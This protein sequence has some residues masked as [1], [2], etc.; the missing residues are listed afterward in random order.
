MRFS[1][2]MLFVVGFSLSCSLTTNAG[3]TAPAIPAKTEIDIRDISL[4]AD[5]VLTGY[6]VNSQGQPVSSAEV[7]VSFGRR[8]I[9]KVKTHPKTGVFS[10]HKL[11]GGVHT[12]VVNGQTTIVRFWPEASAPPS[13]RP[14]LTI[15]TKDKVV[16]AQNVS[17]AL[18]A[19]SYN[20]QSLE[21][22][23]AFDNGMD[24]SGFFTP[25][26]FVTTAALAGGVIGIAAASDNDDRDDI[27]SPPSSP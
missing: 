27:V 24:F 18:R 5:G 8:V 17:M 11:R 3:D 9:A 23:G 22:S 26:G 14:K 13:S 19:A 2:A 25:T 12:V 7:V 16:R 10:V 21:R 4:L 6:V 20:M 1:Y 15:V